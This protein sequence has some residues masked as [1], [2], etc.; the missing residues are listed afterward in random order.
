LLLLCCCFT[1]A[2]LLLYCCFNSPHL[3]PSAASAAS[4]SSPV[5][6]REGENPRKTVGEDTVI[7]AMESHLQQELE[8]AEGLVGKKWS[9]YHPTL[10]APGTQFTCFTGIKVQILTEWRQYHASVHSPGP[11]I[12]SG[13]SGRLDLGTHVTCFTG[14]N[15]QILTQK[16]LLAVLGPTL[17]ALLVQEYKH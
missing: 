11:P 2:L 5:P 9:Q 15:V 1:A 10:N 8:S 17:L 6:R 14:T 3:Q 16:A 7:N 13:E 4:S 12:A